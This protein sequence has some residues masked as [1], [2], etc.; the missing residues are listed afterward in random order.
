MHYECG[1]D[2]IPQCY[3]LSADVYVPDINAINFFAHIPVTAFLVHVTDIFYCSN[4][5]AFVSR[6]FV[7][8]VQGNR[9]MD[10]AVP[11]VNIEYH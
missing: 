1:V 5:R 8:S 2:S 11:T 3:V 4:E 6:H 7:V 10:R 9:E